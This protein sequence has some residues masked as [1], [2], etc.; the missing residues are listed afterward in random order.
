MVTA[1]QSEDTAD[2]EASASGPS[3]LTDPFQIRDGIVPED[4]LAG[5]RQR[6]KGKSIAHYQIQQNSVRPAGFSVGDSLYDST[7]FLAAHPGSLETYGRTYGGCQ[8]GRSSCTITSE[9][10][11]SF[12]KCS[13]SRH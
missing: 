10:R 12:Y 11:P 1:N 8:D 4:E 5:L 2:V 13:L 7:F 6:K 3:S 9:C